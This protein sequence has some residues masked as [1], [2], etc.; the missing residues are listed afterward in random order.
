LE[1]ARVV[2][3]YDETFAG[4][5]ASLRVK[6][7]SAHLDNFSSPSSCVYDRGE[8]IESL[9]LALD[10]GNRR[11]YKPTGLWGD[12]PAWKKATK[13]FYHSVLGN[14]PQLFHVS[15]PATAIRS[16]ANDVHRY[17]W[18][19]FIRNVQEPSP[20]DEI[21]HDVDTN[22]P[23]SLA[24]LGLYPLQAYS[25]IFPTRTTFHNQIYLLGTC[26]QANQIPMVLAWMKE[27]KIVPFEKTVAMALVF[28][29]EVSLRAPLFEQFGGEGEYSK[30]LRWLEAWVGK[31]GMPGPQMMTNVSKGIAK[32]REGHDK[33]RA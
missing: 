8:V 9:R 17:P 21:L 11:K 25:T 6:R 33:F 12:T 24:R 7:S 29:A 4:F 32:V 26:G 14:N 2:I 3:K 13:I 19:E 16:S 30:L 1:I 18:A 27:L 28:W 23:A 31:S 5:W 20:V 15:S 22:S 10:G